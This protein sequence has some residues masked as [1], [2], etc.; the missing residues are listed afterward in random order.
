MIESKQ[1]PRQAWTSRT[2]IRIATAIALGAII[3]GAV[4]VRANADP[5]PPNCV[6]QPW[7]YGSAGRMTVRTLCDGPIQP[8]GSW[9][10]GRNFYA[11]GYMAAGNS[12]CSGGLYS[13]FCTYNPPHWVPEFDTG[14]E[15]Y[16]VTP[17]T[18]L[19]DEP[20]HIGVG[21]AA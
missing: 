21:S 4:E 6:Q 20:G 17:D 13:S 1:R 8:D 7:W 18:V 10:R 3:T 15:M 16:R 2:T 19:P 12:Y 9:T 11:A 14:A 5:L